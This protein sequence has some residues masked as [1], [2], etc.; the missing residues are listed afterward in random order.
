VKARVLVVDDEEEMRAY[1]RDALARR[2]FSVE[3]FATAAAA[4][5]ALD[6]AAADFDVV[7]TDLRMKGGDGLGLTRLVRETRPD[8]PVVVMTAYGSVDVVVEALRSGGAD[9]VTKPFALDVLVHTLTRAVE[10]RRLKRELSLLR[11]R[12]VVP[13]D[14]FGLVGDSSPMQRLRELVVDVARLESNVLIS[15]ESGSGKELVARALHKASRRRSG[16]LVAV[17]VSALPETLLESLLFGHVRGAF[18]DAREA[19]TGLFAQA[20][21]GTLFLDEIGD[22]PLNLQPKLLRVL[23]ERR[24]RPLGADHEVEFDG[25]LVCATHRDLERAIDDGTFR[26][27]LFYRV[28]VIGIEVPALRQRRSDILPLAA[29]FV[30]QTSTAN[31]LPL[32]RISPA[33][34]QLLTSW[35][36]PGNVRE[37]Q[38]AIERA[39]GL[40]RSDEIAPGDLP[41][42]L[43]RTASPA[44]SLLPEAPGEETWD[45]GEIER[46]HILHVLQREGGNRQKTAALLGIARRTLYRKLQEYGIGDPGRDDD[47]S[48]Q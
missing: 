39:A 15:G 45:L 47:G 21:G 31:G 27:D 11:E 9:F 32:R 19:R 12:P 20:K 1:L 25:R 35:S 41:P 17:N 38:N 33:A 34:A 13:A 7:L 2:G 16:E 29:H 22:L 6:A 4:T 28:N 30:R 46:R 48:P 44:T 14:G 43:L 36:W 3:V 18:T 23:Q 40:A 42:R 5:A 37:L 26:E 24:F 8:L 10:N